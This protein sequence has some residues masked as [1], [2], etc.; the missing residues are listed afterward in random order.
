MMCCRGKECLISIWLKT[1]EK[2]KCMDEVRFFVDIVF[3]LLGLSI[4]KEKWRD[5][6]IEEDLVCSFLEN[7]YLLS[8]DFV[9][10]LG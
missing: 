9:I 3:G 8:V 2:K 10:L 1:I 7:R 4:E 5:I 6:L